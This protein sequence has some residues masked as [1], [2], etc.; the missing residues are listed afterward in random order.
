M[1]SKLLQHLLLGFCILAFPTLLSA[2]ECSSQGNCDAHCAP[3]FFRNGN[4]AIGAG[5]P[6]CTKIKVETVP[7]QHNSP[8]CHCVLVLAAALCVPTGIKKDYCDGDCPVVFPTMQDAINN[9]NPIEG[10][11]ILQ[12]NGNNA[13][14]ACRYIK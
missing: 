7:G 8:E 11:C 10:E 3:W 2:Q 6:T 12:K 1:K 9:T 13:Y 14:C 5:V 4:G